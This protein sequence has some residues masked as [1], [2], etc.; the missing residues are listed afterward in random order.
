MRLM[1]NLRIPQRRLSGQKAWL[2]LETNVFK[3]RTNS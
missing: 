1:S 3:A 2:V